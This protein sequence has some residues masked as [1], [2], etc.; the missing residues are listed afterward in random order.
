MSAT[1]PPDDDRTVI[2]GASGPAA[3]FKPATHNALPIGTRV[4]E[5]EIIG[6]VGEGGFGIVY[7][8]YDASLDRNVALKEYMPSEL[9]QREDGSRVAV[10]SQRHSETF[11]AG[12]RSFINEARMLAQFDHPSLVKVYRFYEANG[13][14]YMVMPF[15]EGVTLKQALAE[16]GTP[17]DE[18][19]LKGLLAQLLDALETIHARQCYHRDIAP[20]NIL[21]LR[22]G[23]P[24][25][26]DFGA[27]RRVI[28]DMTQALTVILKPGYAPIEQ[29]AEVPNLKQGPWTDLY[30]LASVIYFAISGKPPVPAVARVMSDPLVPL[31]QAASGRYSAGFL[32]GIDA[33]LAVKPEGRPQD[34]SEFRRAVGIEEWHTPTRRVAA[35]AIAAAAAPPK[36]SA[37]ASTA[38]RRS[39]V[40]IYAAA[41]VGLLFAIGVSIAIFQSRSEPPLPSDRQAQAPAAQVPAVDTNGAAQEARTIPVPFEEF[42]THAANRLAGFDCARL[43][44]TLEGGVAH[45][46]GHVAAEADLQRITAEVGTIRGVQRVDSRGVSVFP[47]PYCEVVTLLAPFA[48]RPGSL[49]VALKD[50]RT[51]IVEGSKL[52]AEAAAADFPGYLY[53]DLYDLDG[54]VA[55]MLPNSV[56]SRNQVKPGQRL[57]LGEHG[58]KWIAEPPLGK[59]LLVVMASGS[60]LFPRGR[61]EL[62]EN[63]DAYLRELRESLARRT[64][65]EPFA[66]YYTM[67][68]FLPKR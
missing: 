6:L 50:G 5:F 22:D 33:A 45:V 59:H 60:P 24:L 27:A 21:I 32:S 26:L 63:G 9:A 28:G 23:K 42:A 68:D 34:V 61:R 35:P 25:L 29:Y 8:A 49:R 47:P 18:N 10:K 62:V 20:D 12:M 2:V 52:V 3:P 54:H 36:A 15:Y 37:S 17:P 1:P 67:I 39:I 56:E 43:D 40:P 38:S 58:V 7:L 31:S 19:W 44:A 57:V 4:G 30:A 53:V 55:H 51:T 46:R 64:A 16:L 65:D 41:G 14:A 66:V 11:L 48:E 13:T